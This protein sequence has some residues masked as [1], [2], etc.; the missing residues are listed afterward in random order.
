MIFIV[1]LL[2]QV[3]TEAYYF[4]FFPLCEQTSDFLCYFFVDFGFAEYGPSDLKNRDALADD[5]L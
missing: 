3:N 5:R 2:L 4:N 1:K